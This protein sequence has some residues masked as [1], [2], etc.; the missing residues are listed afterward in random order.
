MVS[1][2]SIV[3]QTAEQIGI[4]KN[5]KKNMKK[6]ANVDDFSQLKEQVAA[7]FADRDCSWRDLDVAVYDGGN[8]LNVT[9]SQM[10]EFLPLTFAHLQKLS[11]I[12]ETKDFNVNNWSSEGCETCDYGSQYAHEFHVPK[13]K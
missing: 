9:V 1:D 8:Y 12:F 10:Y 6:A 13:V 7:V 5:M 11:E 3:A 2:T 4:G